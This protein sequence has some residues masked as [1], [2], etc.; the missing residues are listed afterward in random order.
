MDKVVL[1]FL[2]GYLVKIIKKFIKYWEKRSNGYGVEFKIH[3]QKG[4]ESKNIGWWCSAQDEL[5]Y[6]ESREIGTN[7][8][9]KLYSIYKKYY[10][11]LIDDEFHS[12]DVIIEHTNEPCSN[13]TISFIL[14]KRVLL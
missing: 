9:V 5:T 7:L 4:V 11:L 14:N 3:I 13:T 10:P 12:L 6:S 8:Y 1:K 2:E